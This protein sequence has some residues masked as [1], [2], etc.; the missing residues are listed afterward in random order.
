MINKES[1][2]R[3][4]RAMD[5]WEDAREVEGGRFQATTIDDEEEEVFGP[6][7]ARRFVIGYIGHNRWDQMSIGE[8][9]SQSIRL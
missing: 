7:E 3:M 5:Q 6:I 4:N 1:W 2:A 8:S 9:S